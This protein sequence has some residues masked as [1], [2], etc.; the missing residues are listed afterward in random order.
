MNQTN[1]PYPNKF[2]AGDIAI[3]RRSINFTDG[4]KH[5][6]GEHILVREGCASYYNVNHEDY[7]RLE[8]ISDICV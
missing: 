1:P 6:K 8:H 2:K 4:T 5:I 3:C 7:D